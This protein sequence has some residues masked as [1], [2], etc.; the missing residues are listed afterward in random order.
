VVPGPGLHV[1]GYDSNPTTDEL[2]SDKLA[3]Y[4]R[5]EG[6]EPLEKAV[7][8]MTSLPAQRL[9]LADR[10]ELRPGAFAD[11]VVFDPKTIIDRATY[12]Q[13]RSYPEG[14][15][16][17]FVNGVPAVWNGEETGRLA[18]RALRGDGVSG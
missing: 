7:R 15:A 9:R 14:I 6:L 1:I 2:P 5:E 10:G 11:M 17:V 13:P 4:V 3:V 18:G 12:E 8:K 16:H